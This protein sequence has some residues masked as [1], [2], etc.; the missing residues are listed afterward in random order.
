MQGRKYSGWLILAVTLTVAGIAWDLRSTAT[1][2]FA[3]LP[4]RTLSDWAKDSLILTSA[5]FH[6]LGLVAVVMGI[7]SDCRPLLFWNLCNFSLWVGMSVS[8][9]MRT[10]ASKWPNLEQS[11]LIG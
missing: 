2:A 11:I 3:L 5:L 1:L 8:R 10:D 9:F 7:K 4:Y 6:G